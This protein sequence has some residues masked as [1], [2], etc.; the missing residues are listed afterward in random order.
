MLLFFFLFELIVYVFFFF[1]FQAEDGIRDYKVTG[2]QTCALPIAHTKHRRKAERVLQTFRPGHRRGLEKLEERGFSTLFGCS[3]WCLRTEAFDVRFRLAGVPAGGE[4]SAGAGNHRRL[5]PGL[6]AGHQGKSLRRQRGG[7]LSAEGDETWTCS[8]GTRLCSSPGAGRELA[9]PS[10]AAARAK[11]RSPCSWIKTWRLQGSSKKSLVT[12][13]RSAASL[14][15]TSSLR[16]LAP[17]SSSK[18][19]GNLIIWMCWSTT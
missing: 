17:R 7:I 16:K 2:V 15:P 8:L 14:L 9:R 5:R 19:S 10:C 11:A 3:L 18:R 12:G 4:L 1:F 6:R 13:A